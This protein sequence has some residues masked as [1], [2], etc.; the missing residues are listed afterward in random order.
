MSLAN[1]RGGAALEHTAGTASEESSLCAEFILSLSMVEFQRGAKTVWAGELKA[2]E[3]WAA[4]NPP[5]MQD[6]QAG[7]G[8]GPQ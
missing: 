4:M 1:V 6:N 2:A 7:E 3:V 8:A 5:G